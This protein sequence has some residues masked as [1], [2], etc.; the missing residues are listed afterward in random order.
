MTKKKAGRIGLPLVLYSGGLRD[1]FFGFSTLGARGF[2]SWPSTSFAANRTVRRMTW[3][4][5]R[6]S[7]TVTFVAALLVVTGAR[8]SGAMVEG[9]G[10]LQGG[11]LGVGIEIG[12]SGSVTLDSDSPLLPRLVSYRWTPLAPG[13][14]FR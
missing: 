8:P 5:R 6:R 11:R 14:R 10:E 13:R 12:T 9:S 7:A 2:F 3:W 1:Y 4:G